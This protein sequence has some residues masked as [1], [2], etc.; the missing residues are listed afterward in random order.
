MNADQIARAICFTPWSNEDIS[1]F[2]EAVKFARAQL[3]RANIREFVAGDS[4]RFNSTK[5][6]SMSGTVEK[7]A[8]KYVTVRTPR[9]LYKVPANMLVVA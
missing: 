4:V 6:G 5:L 3:T 9:G 8:I 2:V 1:K 7:V